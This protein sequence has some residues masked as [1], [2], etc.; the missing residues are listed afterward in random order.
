MAVDQISRHS[1]RW[2]ESAQCIV[3]TVMKCFLLSSMPLLCWR[4]V[5][6]IV[7]SATLQG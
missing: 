5:R 7:G 2:V 1:L 4:I 3:L 6:D